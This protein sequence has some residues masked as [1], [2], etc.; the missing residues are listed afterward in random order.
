MLRSNIAKISIRNARLSVTVD[1]IICKSNATFDIRS[2]HINM[3]K[4][5]D[6]SIEFM[7][8]V[9]ENEGILINCQFSVW[10][11]SLLEDMTGRSNISTYVPYMY[12]SYRRCNFEPLASFQIV[13]DGFH[14]FISVW[15]HQLAEAKKWFFINFLSSQ[16]Y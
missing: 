15:I 9:K 6:W 12:I 13:S 5:C 4:N 7:S 8:Q 3:E 11:E 1:S 16:E 14:I 10:G 2:R